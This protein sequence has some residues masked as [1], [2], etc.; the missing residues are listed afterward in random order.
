MYSN[1][2]KRI[3]MSRKMNGSQKPLNT[4]QWLYHIVLERRSLARAC[5]VPARQSCCLC[6]NSYCWGTSVLDVKRTGLEN[7]LEV[8]CTASALLADF[9]F[10]TR[11][12]WISGDRVIVCDLS[13]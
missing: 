6:T 9:A 8:S 7:K 3:M 11:K 12:S 4:L 2:Q 13:A 5:C 10:V 1:K